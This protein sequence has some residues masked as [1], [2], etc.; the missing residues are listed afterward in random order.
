MN[1]CTAKLPIDELCKMGKKGR[2]KGSEKLKSLD[3]ELMEVLK[4]KV[5]TECILDVGRKKGMADSA[6]QIEIEDQ[7]VSLS[8]R[9]NKLLLNVHKI[10]TYMA[11]IDGKFLICFSFDFRYSTTKAASI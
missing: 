5:G 6:Q 7:L 1:P 9:R 3:K 2:K 11:Q 10:R 4:K 8:N